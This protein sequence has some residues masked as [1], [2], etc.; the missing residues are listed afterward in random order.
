M[1]LRP[2]FAPV[3]ISL[4]L[5][6]A[7]GLS[8]AQQAPDYPQAQRDSLVED[9]FGTRVPAPYRWME[10]LSSPGVAAFV[11]SENALTYRMLDRMPVRDSLRAMLTE[12]WNSRRVGIPSREADGHLF[13]RA[14]SGLQRQSVLY[15]RDSID[16]PPEVVL[17]PNTLSPDGSIALQ[18]T[19]IS[20]DGQYLAYGLSEG[21]SDLQ[22]WYVREM[23]SGRVLPD[24]IRN[25]KFSSASW[26]HDDRG[27]F[28]TRYDIPSG[29]KA[30]VGATTGGKIYYHTLGTPQLQD[31]LI[32][33]RPDDPHLFL[34]GGVSEDGRFL[35][36]FVSEGGSKNELWYKDLGDPEHPDLSA[37]VRALSAVA[38]AEYSTL[39]N[40][41]DTVYLRTDLD[42]PNRRIVAVTLPDTARA[43]WRTVVPEGENVIE[44]ATMAGDRIAVQTLEDVKSTLTLYDHAGN[45]VGEVALPGIGTVRGLNGRTDRPELWYAF[46]SFLS[47]TTV[48][49]YDLQTGESQP[50]EPPHVAFDPSKFETK[51]VFYSSKDGTRVPMFIVAKKGLSLDGNNP[52]LMYAYGGFD[53]SMLPGYSPTTMAWLEKGGVYAVPNLRGG[54]EYG[55]AWHH[56]GMRE[57]KQNVFDDFIA[58]GE[59]LIDQG[60]TRPER[61]AIS[62][63]SN[64]G[65]L[66]GAVMTQRP[67]L[68]GVALPAVGVMDMLRYQKFT[69]GAF[70][71]PEYG[72]SDDSTAFQYLIRYSPVQNVR[73]GT[74]YPATLLTTA[75]HDDRVVPSH[76]YKFTAALQHAQGCANPILLRVETEGSHGYRPTDKQIAEAADKLGFAWHYLMGRE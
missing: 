41:G 51:Q 21:G 11:K 71:V 57:K 69:G 55:E 73:E 7:P 47:P 59:Y 32:Y 74:C 36:I 64:G 6:L 34:G 18:G 53:I 16:A 13:Y 2:S 45:R 4:A 15:E 66:V 58:A 68:F 17:D 49:H 25:V 50:F 22:S 67:E 60:Y 30:L 27:F 10:D 9:Y 38:D 12:L 61:L 28:Y 23:E 31:R 44:G 14:N 26:T 1:H 40:V 37:P 5:L 43:H 20:P 39:G 56:A 35:F 24:T 75:D 46:T 48:Y 19:S 54:G 70:W 8:A 62:G 33:A 65:L 52:V 63:G 76:T 3:A 42:A 72:S 29:D